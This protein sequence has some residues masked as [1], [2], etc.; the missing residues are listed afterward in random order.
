MQIYVDINLLSFIQV[1]STTKY[2]N[3]QEYI[4]KE[5][6]IKVILM[7]LMQNTNWYKVSWNSK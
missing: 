3:W 6:P 5:C 1:V 4:K 2:D 7:Y